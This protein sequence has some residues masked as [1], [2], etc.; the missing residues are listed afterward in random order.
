MMRS[1]RLL[2]AVSIAALVACPLSLRALADDQPATAPA[3]APAAGDS[4]APAAAAAPAPAGE[5][6]S[7]IPDASNMPNPGPE[8][9]KDTVDD[10][11][12]YGIVG[13]YDLA[14]SAG[15]AILARSEPPL[16]ILHVFEAE[17]SDRNE[18]LDKWL[19]RWADLTGKAGTPA[20]QMSDV[21]QQIIQLLNKG[22]YSLRHDLKYIDQNIERLTDGERGFMNGV[23]ALR[24]SG[25]LAVPEMIDYLKDP[26]KAQYHDA[27]RQA[28]VSLGRP[29]LNPLLAATDMKDTTTLV[30]I[31]SVLRDIGYDAADPYLARLSQ[32]KDQPAEVHTAADAALQQLNAPTGAA[33]A[34]LFYNLAEKF[35]YNNSALS[36][37]PQ[38]TTAMMWQWKAGE[39]DGKEVPAAIFNDL[40]TMR[41]TRNALQLAADDSKALS[42]W[43]AANNKLEADLP[44]GQTNPLAEPNR[45]SADYFNVRAGAQ[46]MNAIITRSLDDH[47]SAVLY[48]AIHSL[49]EIAGPSSLFSGTTGTPLVQA[50]QYP[51]RRVRY[52]A[53]FTLAAGMPQQPFEGS[54][55]VVPLLAEA[56]A[57]NGQANVLVIAPNTDE[58]GKL[59]DALKNYNTAGGTSVESAVADSST[60]P[61]VDV[62][63]MTE[64]LGADEMS[65]LKTLMSQDPR[66]AR[67]AKVIIVKSDASP[68]ARDALSDP[69]LSITEA[70]D[71]TGLAKA[72]DDAR[73]RAGNLPLDEKTADADALRSADLLHLLAVTHT[74]AY[75]LAVSEG[76]LLGA[77]K[78]KRADV[79]KAAALSIGFLDSKQVQSG[80]LEVAEADATPDDVKIALYNAMA[81]SAKNFGNRLSDDEVDSLEKVVDSAANLDVRTA[82]AAAAGALNLPTDQA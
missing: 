17:A 76:S 18:S 58:R 21:S 31:I 75:D 1:R 82:A 37:V 38:A 6:V 48:R 16:D 8:S 4:A 26:N 63:L 39:L 67:A 43:L 3:A 15:K 71:S 52:E 40:M 7:P 62:I 27:I 46:Y 12:H 11:W 35:Y 41:E 33:P 19:L 77:L 53:A 51:E 30:T 61:S 10:Y 24:D 45:P 64:D 54:E 2:A 73:G 14:A 25:E 65:R 78:D 80:L 22:R 23:A 47:N 59:L 70:T 42:L 29:V 9:L 68:Y 36:P 60:L 44:E 66:L 81:Q 56:L 5:S 49:G 32:D 55:Q 74:K 13:R 69:M 57:Q 72:I 79:A 20:A 50:M 34:D 28:L